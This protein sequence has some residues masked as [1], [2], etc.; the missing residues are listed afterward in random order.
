MSDLQIENLDDGSLRVSETSIEGRRLTYVVA[1]ADAHEWLVQRGAICA[2]HDHTES[3]PTDDIMH[4]YDKAK[5][6][7]TVLTEQARALLARDERVPPELLAEG[8]SLTKIVRSFETLGNTEPDRKERRELID[9][10]NVL[11]T[12]RRIAMSDVVSD[13]RLD[14]IAAID[15]E[16][17][18]KRD[19]LDF[20]DVCLGIARVTGEQ[21]TREQDPKGPTS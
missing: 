1:A 7:L 8:K 15:E 11:L 10:I 14:N 3:E 6:R 18:V 2:E 5:D 21:E 9:R 4:R 12:Q 20:L 17:K 13:G 19:R 16:L